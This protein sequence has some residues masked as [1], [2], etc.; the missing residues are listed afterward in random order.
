MSQNS[1]RIIFIDLMRAFAVFMMIQGHT[2]DTFLADEYR[3]FDSLFYSIW[4]FMR[5][6]TAPIF[7]FTS[8]LIFTYLLKVNSF[9]FSDNPRV[10]K[11]IKR[12]LLLITIGYL[13]RYPTYR[14]FDFRYVSSEQWT[15]FFTVDALHLIGFGLL[16]IIL[17]YYLSQKVNINFNLVAIAFIFVIFILTP[18]MEN[19]N[20]NYYLPEYISAYLTTKNGSLFPFFPWLIYVLAGGLLGNFLRNN[21][22]KYLQ[23]RFVFAFFSI[24]IIFISF[25]ITID[26]FIGFVDNKIYY[27]LSLWSIIFLR[28]GA[29]SILNAIIVSIARKAKKIPEII[30]EIGRKTLL[31][32][33]VHL[34]IL[35]GCVLMPGLNKFYGKSFDVTQTLIAA[36]LMLISMFSLILIT[37]KINNIRSKKLVYEK[38]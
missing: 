16:F 15:I 5:G 13:L 3:T 9:N 37:N 14:I 26:F 29:V 21:E 35:Y 8:G 19:L 4:Y 25:S 6:F 34:I 27:N 2:V 10:I 7:M 36:A 23:K 20:W 28:I 1:N 24:G 12:G 11:G 31:L 30:M 33:V 22:L 18:I 38:I 17:V 32:Y